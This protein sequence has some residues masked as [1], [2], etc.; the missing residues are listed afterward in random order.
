MTI[1]ARHILVDQEFEAKDLLNIGL[2]LT[3][4]DF[5]ILMLLVPILW[6]MIGIR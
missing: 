6:P 1:K 5:F 2:I 3:V 4:V